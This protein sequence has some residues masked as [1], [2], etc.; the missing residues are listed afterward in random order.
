MPSDRLAINSSRLRR[1]LGGI[2]DFG[3]NPDT[4]GYNRVGYSDADMAARE[5]LLDQMRTAGLATRRD[6]V[7]N[8]FGRFGPM[9]GPCIMA[10]S[11]LDTVP[12]GGHFDGAI[13]V[14][15][16]PDVVL[17]IRGARLFTSEERRGRE[18][19]GVKVGI[20]GEAV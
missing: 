9:D 4:G 8:L 19:C 16:A 12:V 14:A 5:W 15:V 18:G 10:G 3:F 13:G 2:N 7:A 11:P 6:G 20:G 1:L 17:T